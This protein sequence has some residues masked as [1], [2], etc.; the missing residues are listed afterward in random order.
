M[1]RSIL[2]NFGAFGAAFV[3]DRVISFLFM[4]YA[5]R[6]LGPDLLGQYLLIGTYVLFFSV[7]FTAG[8]LPVAVREIVRQRENPRSILE[9]VL[10]LRLVLGMLAY[11][12][13]ML[14][15]GLVLPASTFLPLAALAGTTLIIDAFKDSFS[16]Y[17][18]AFERMAIPSAF[19]VANGIFTAT[20][21]VILLY[22]DFGLVALFAGTAMINL[23][24]TTGWHILFSRRFQPYRLRF[25]VSAWKHMLIMVAP[26][27][28]L[29]LAAQFNRLANVMMLSLVDGPLPRERA[30]GY[31]GPAQ[32]IANFPLGLLFGLRRAMVPPVADKLR[33]GQ[34][35]NDEF[36]AA[37][38]VAIVFIA[39][40]LL[41]A[42]SLFAREI[43]LLVFGPGYA[44]AVVPLR[45]L[46]GAAALW[47]VATLPENFLVCYPEQKFTRFLAG[48]YTPLLVN[49]ALCLI[50]IPRYGVVGA[51][52]AIM[53]GRGV[54]LI[55]VLHYC[56]ALLP[57]DSLGFVRMWGALVV[58]CAT[59][60]GC[61]LA[62]LG[63]EQPVLRAL[64]VA[65]LALAGI[66]A[67]GHRELGKLRAM[68]F[69][70]ARHD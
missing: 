13:L 67:A 52:F 16:A 51:A 5:A 48:A 50:L 43:L 45:F 20:S 10:S 28:P 37:L 18:T 41:V 65:A 14:I 12:T 27:A 61:L 55:F 44:D 70:R 25:S 49:V 33:R 53:V 17:H 57:L 19:Q 62:S 1:L 42:T 3:A 40:P 29:Q 4:V 39:F 21:G 64:A 36:A 22:L 54:N 26:I 66:L 68:I 24:I 6:K 15:T 30:V 38:K 60:A 7:T 35:I 11:A 2:R 32:Q 58:L 34:P 56:R 8:L 9:Q 59:Y 23:A 63:I 46:G 69:R 47:I 31:F